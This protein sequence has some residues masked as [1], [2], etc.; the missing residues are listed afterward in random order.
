MWTRPLPLPGRSGGYSPAPLSC[1]Q[2]SLGSLSGSL[3][4]LYLCLS[5]STRDFSLSDHRYLVEELK[6]REGFELVM[7][8]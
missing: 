6:K 7:E 3:L 5:S 2:C 4:F 8:V 1:S